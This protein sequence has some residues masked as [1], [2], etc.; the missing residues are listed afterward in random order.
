VVDWLQPFERQWKVDRWIVWRP[1]FATAHQ[2]PV[3]NSAGD[4]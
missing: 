3:G 2:N 1:R 4:L